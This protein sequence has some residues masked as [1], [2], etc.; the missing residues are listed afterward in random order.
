MCETAWI[1]GRGVPARSDRD[2]LEYGRRFDEGADWYRLHP[3][4]VPVTAEL[5]SAA[6]PVGKLQPRI[7]PRRPVATGPIR[8]IRADE[9]GARIASWESDAPPVEPDAR[10]ID[11]IE[12]DD[13]ADRRPTKAA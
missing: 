8:G 11:L 12:G 2:D 13:Y 4:A 1:D 3:V 6:H 10:W 9:L 5:D 7:H